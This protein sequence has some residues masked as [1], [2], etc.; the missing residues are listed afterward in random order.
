MTQSEALAAAYLQAAAHRD[1]AAAEAEQAGRTD[2]A[3]E[4][5]AH[6]AENRNLAAEVT[7]VPA[8]DPEQVRKFLAAANLRRR[9]WRLVEDGNR[10]AALRKVRAA[11][12]WD[13]GLDDTTRTD[14]RKEF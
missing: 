1:A 4:H 7:Q 13:D 11:H 8:D 5:R 6:A 9:A 2:L 3:A 14:H 12:T 10:R